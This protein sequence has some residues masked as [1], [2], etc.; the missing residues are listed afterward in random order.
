MKARAG[1]DATTESE[2]LHGEPVMVFE[3]REGWAWIQSGIDDY[4]G[5]VEAS[6]IGPAHAPATH[7]VSVM[8]T[9]LYPDADLKHPPLGALSLGSRLA[10]GDLVE[11]RGTAYRLVTGGGGAV[12]AD[13][14]VPLDAAPENDHVAVAERFLNVPY[15][16]GG[17]TSHGVDCSAL[18][19]LALMAVG[20]PC[21]RDTDL[22]ETALGNSVE[23][24]ADAPRQ[25]GD[26]V[27]WPGHVGITLDN[28]YMIHASGHH[29]MVVIEPLADA[30][31]RIAGK[32]GRP[33]SL[34]RL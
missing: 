19:Q 6:A 3:E 12:I 31:E 32:V 15:L 29:M 33:T 4:V 11:V 24:G 25:P 5:Y 10:L 34:R 13:H 2:L 23:G 7:R 17:R 8:S 27:F 30:I 28:E 26:F 18:V 1:A 22:Q 16:W 21:P 20:T 9:F 14:V